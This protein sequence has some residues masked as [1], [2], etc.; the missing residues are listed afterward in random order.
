MPGPIPAAGAVSNPSHYG[1]LAMGARQFTGIWTQRSPYRDAAVEYLVSKFYGGSRFDSILD[2]INRE[3]TQRMTDQRSP[4]SVVFN[5][6]TFPAIN[7]FAAWKFIQ[8]QVEQF[9]TLADG[10]DGNVYDATPGQ[11]T[12]L[13]AKNAGAGRT[14]F[15]GVNTTMFTGDG[16]KARKILRSAKTWKANTLYNVGDYIIDPAGR[17]QSIQATPQTYTISNSA[18]I[19]ALGN[20]YAVLTLDR[21][22]PVIPA[23][24]TA[25]FAGLTVLVGLNAMQ[26]MWQGY[27]QAVAAQLALG[28]NQIAFA[29][30]GAPQVPTADTGTMVALTAVSGT[31]GAVAPV[32]GTTFGQVVNDGGLFTGVNWT[33]FLSAVQNWGIQPGAAPAPPAYDG[34]NT[35]TI[36][37]VGPI[38]Y[39]LPNLNYANGSITAVIDANQNIQVA[40]NASGGIWT[41]GAILPAWAT[42]IG[43]QT[44]DGQ[45][46]WICYGA[47]GAWYAAN[48]YGGASGGVPN[49]CVILDPNGNLQITNDVTTAQASSAGPITWAT[50]IGATTADGTITWTCIGFGSI[51][52]S[53]T[54]Q[55]AWSPHCIDGS[56]G[57]ATPITQVANGG[58]GPSGAFQLTIDVDI[59][60]TA[61]ETDPQCDQLWLWRTAQGQPTLILLGIIPNPF[62]KGLLAI[63]YMDVSRDAD[64]N[65]QIP[66]PI[67]FAAAPPPD[68]ITA[69]AFHLKRDWG[70]VDNTV[71]WSGGPDTVTGNGLTAFP[72]LNVIPYVA[73]PIKLIPV[74]V[75]DGGIL[76]LTTDG[77]YIILGSGQ[78][79]DPFYST[80][81]FDKVDVQNYDAI[82]TYNNAVFLME[83]NSKVSTVAIQYPFNPQS[84]YT[85]I[86]FPIG[87]QFLKVTTGGISAALYDPATA[88]LSWNIQNT[89]ETAMYVAD[90]AVGWFRMS[91]V[92]PPESGLLWS[93]RR[94]ILGG[95]SAVQAV[96]TGPKMRQLLIA[97]PAGTPGPILCRDATQTVWTDLPAGIATGYP[98]WDAKGVNVL[99]STGQVS[100][101]AHIATKSTAVG[102]RPQVSVLL[103]E[104]APSTARPWDLLKLDFKSEDPPT[105]PASVSAYSNRYVLRQNGEANTGDCILTKFDYGSQT[106]GDE[107]LDWATLAA[108]HEEREA[109][110]A[111]T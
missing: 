65:A 19:V 2:G 33:C 106:V 60:G 28:P 50:T 98:A 49:P 4:G 14:R 91:A 53:G 1:A 97:P 101:V 39:W 82:D 109:Q 79:S 51:L 38:F 63:N 34:T 23:N 69:P 103:G 86:G 10:A 17:V 9:R 13:Y 42:V 102:A 40:N 107:L 55:Y 77:I 81:Y 71:V 68:N 44:T 80:S 18:V 73:Q 105:V 43:G 32:W 76:V 62:L 108:V 66:A 15:L 59:A 8:N 72:P 27:S 96:Q 12:T 5:T 7:S 111:K 16:N 3:I 6:N 64:L 47:V 41:G 85:E 31:T 67:A 26:L 25:N 21:T 35:L 87:D 46:Q 93:P 74:T 99:C 94:A 29:Y 95:T 100:E 110:A 11:K 48:N 75:Q 56:V 88:Y 90:G 20:S 24:Q 45:V 22:A 78:A 58:L 84:G 92:S 83:S 61:A 30:T 36:D 52:W 54:L 70:I 89:Y 37:P 104:I 57:T